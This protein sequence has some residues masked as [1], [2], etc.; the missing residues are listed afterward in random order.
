MDVKY[1]NFFELNDLEKQALAVENGRNF[2]RQNFTTYNARGIC[3]FRIETFTM[4]ENRKICRE[5]QSCRVWGHSI[6]R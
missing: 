4:S 5:K 3:S 1:L 6:K 2:R